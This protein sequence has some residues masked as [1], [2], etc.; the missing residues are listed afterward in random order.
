MIL[1]NNPWAFLKVNGEEIRKIVTAVLV[2]RRCP[3]PYRHPDEC[4]QFV[5]TEIALRGYHRNY[6]RNHISKAKLSSYLYAT[7]RG[8][9][10]RWLHAE[11]SWN[12]P[13]STSSKIEGVEEGPEPMAEDEVETE[14]T[15]KE[16]SEWLSKAPLLPS[17]RPVWGLW[18]EGYGTTETAVR[19]KCSTAYVSYIRADIRR[20]FKTFLDGKAPSEAEPPSHKGANPQKR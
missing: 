16:F 10:L 11:F 17:T 19:L 5:N 4:L 15:T 6:K 18:M 2:G 1:H 9:V 12:R 7:V 20:A 8:L 13:F 3:L 14:M